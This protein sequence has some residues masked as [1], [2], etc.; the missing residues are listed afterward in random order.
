MNKDT[1][2][3]RAVTREVENLKRDIEVFRKQRVALAARKQELQAELDGINTQI[4][5]HI[6]EI[7]SAQDLIDELEL[8][9]QAAQERAQLTR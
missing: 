9:V 3:A 2:I 5:S 6:T 4:A 1:I 7:K 8:E